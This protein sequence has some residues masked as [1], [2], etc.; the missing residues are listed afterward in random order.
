MKILVINCGSSSIKYKLYEMDDKSVLA[1]GGIEKI[2]LEGSFLK[3][4]IN[5]ETKII[6]SACPTHTE[7]IKLMFDTLLNPEYGAIKSLDEISAAGHRIVAGGRFTKS[8]I[9]T[10]QM[11]EEWKQYM[12][13]A[14]LHS[15]AHLKGYVA[16]KKMLPNLPQVF[17]FDTA[18]HQTMPAKAYMY[19]VPYK[20]Y[21]Q[22]NIRR[23]GAH[24][25]S[26]RFVTARVCELL[27]VKPEEV[28]IVT[29]HIGNGAS[30]SAVKFG[31]CVDTSMGLT[32][33]EGLMMGTRSGDIDPSAVLSIMKKEG[34]TPD[35]MSD[36]LNKKSGV[37]GISGISSDI[38]EVEAGIE[39]GDE[40]AKLAMEMYDY[41][42]KKYV[43]AYAAAM[44]G[45]DIV[46]FTA[47]VGEHQWD[48]RR[49]AVHGLEFMGIELDEEKNRKNCGEEEIISTPAS[50]VKVVVVPTD[51][52]LLIA[53]DTLDLIK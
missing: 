45:V 21:E 9:V 47:G 42:I 22:N 20:Y 4:K 27:G 40:H 15:E 53:S 52:E 17:V 10:D 23:W 32:P 38:R 12:E 29:C 41:R 19:A 33:L 37:L 24:G 50:K 13:L 36:L 16:V 44:G 39:A 30:V 25:T 49:G 34:L 51:E 48:V 28:R 31:Q 35:E 1:A 3:T 2:G 18:F 14:P 43:G 26:H 6:E 8:Q 11:L 46:V 5:G 7:G